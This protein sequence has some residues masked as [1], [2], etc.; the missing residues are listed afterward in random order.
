MKFKPDDVLADKVTGRIYYVH[1]I[2][3][4]AT[5]HIMGK[6]DYYSLVFKQEKNG[7]TLLAVDLYCKGCDKR[8]VKIGVL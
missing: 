3:D 2:N 1:S 6:A 7:K 5:N 8:L 4:P